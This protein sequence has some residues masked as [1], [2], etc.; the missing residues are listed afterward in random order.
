MFDASTSRV[1]TTMNTIELKPTLDAVAACSVIQGPILLTRSKSD[2]GPD[3]TPMTT[4]ITVHRQIYDRSIA[5]SA[6]PAPFSMPI[7]V[8]GW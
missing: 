1:I 5:I 7:A 8:F 3:D 4:R 2:L 6:N